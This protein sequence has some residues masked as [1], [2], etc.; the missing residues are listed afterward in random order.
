[1][2]RLYTYPGACHCGDIELRLESDKTPSELG[3]RAD[4]CS[5]CKKHG[6][7]YTA[8]PAGEVCV[9]LRHPGVAERYRF[10]TRTAEFLVCKTCGV[11]TAAYV[12]E[13]GLAVVNVNVLEARTDFLSSPILLADFDGESTEE[14][15]LRRRAR[16]TP[17]VSFET[18]RCPPAS[19]E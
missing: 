18:R 15:L 16:W 3:L 12:S 10:G 17:V 1:M 14:R 7:L 9:A 19:P 2:S 6:A 4:T 8:D 11:F 5:F 13:P